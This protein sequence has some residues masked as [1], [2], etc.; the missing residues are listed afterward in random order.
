MGV[1]RDANTTWP[2][3][4]Y[5][6]ASSTSYSLTDNTTL[7]V[8]N[9][10]V[11]KEL[12]LNRSQLLAYAQ[13]SASMTVDGATVSGT[14]PSL[15]D[16]LDAASAYAGA[17]SDAVHYSGGTYNQPGGDPGYYGNKMILAIGSD[18]KLE[19]IVDGKTD[20][21]DS[22]ITGVYWISVIAT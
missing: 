10:S 14:G 3:Y 17:D 22:R 21:Y 19:L 5:Q 4:D 15:K 13:H 20:Y 8:I 16:L 11:G 2:D 9:G 6:W 1:I 18:N 7:L 12:K